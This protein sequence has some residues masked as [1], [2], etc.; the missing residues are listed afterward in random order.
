MSDAAIPQKAGQ[1]PSCGGRGDDD[2]NL[3]ESPRRVQQPL[4]ET[5]WKVLDLDLDR[6]V[7]GGGLPV[8]RHGKALL[9][10]LAQ[11]LTAAPGQGLLGWAVL[12][13]MRRLWL[14]SRMWSYTTGSSQAPV[15]PHMAHKQ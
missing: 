10:L 14:S 11:S 5:I 7:P 12:F 13:R 2:D 8:R 9:A 1:V 6:W 15:L 3:G 4:A